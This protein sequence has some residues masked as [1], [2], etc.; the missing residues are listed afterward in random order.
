MCVEFDHVMSGNVIALQT[1]YVA[2]SSGSTTT[3]I[4]GNCAQISCVVSSGS[5]GSLAAGVTGVIAGFASS[6]TCVDI[7]ASPVD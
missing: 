3:V 4:F 1:T 2:I 5:Q 7:N 6:A